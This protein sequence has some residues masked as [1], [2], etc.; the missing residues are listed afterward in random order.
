[1]HSKAD[2][3]HGIHRILL[4][5]RFITADGRFIPLVPLLFGVAADG[6]LFGLA[7]DGALFVEDADALF[8]EDANVLFHGDADVLFRGDADG[9]FNAFARLRTGSASGLKMYRPG[10]IQLIQRINIISLFKPSRVP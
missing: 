4:D 8:S 6:L 7:G 1:M 3:C 10:F 9:R 5:G 2:H